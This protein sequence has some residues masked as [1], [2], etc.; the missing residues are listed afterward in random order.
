MERLSMKGC[1]VV[2]F[3]SCREKTVSLSDIEPKQWHVLLPANRAL[4]LPSPG[5]MSFRLPCYL[6]PTHQPNTPLPTQHL[7]NM[8]KL[9]MMK[10]SAR[11]KGRGR[12]N[13]ML[14]LWF[15]I[16]LS[17]HGSSHTL[18]MWSLNFE[19]NRLMFFWK[20]VFY[21]LAALNRGLNMVFFWISVVCFCFVF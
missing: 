3:T 9:A 11:M 19:P 20:K 7:V 13:Q 4:M 12:R 15:R 5:L 14:Q 10:P 1:K 17:P 2:S 21:L 18:N 8:M 6:P 16:A